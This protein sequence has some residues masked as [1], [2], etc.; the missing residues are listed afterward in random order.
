MLVTYGTTIPLFIAVIWAFLHFSPK[1]HELA[2]VWL[3]NIATILFALSTSAAYV[4]YLKHSMET[5]SDF[6]W[7]PVVSLLSSL[8]LT[9][10]IIGLSGLVR[11][12]LVFRNITPNKSLNQ[13][14]ANN[15]PPG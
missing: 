11:N 2:K 3:Y 15:A 6:G 9:S 5:G 4:F 1:T 10:I 14:G 7:W 13:T 12:F 8:V